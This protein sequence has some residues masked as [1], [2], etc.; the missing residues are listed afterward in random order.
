[1]SFK[2]P[3]SLHQPLEYLEI[4]DS[5]QKTSE[6][7]E[8]LELFCSPRGILQQITDTGDFYCQ[9]RTQKTFIVIRRPIGYLPSIEDYSRWKMF[10]S[11][12]K[13]QRS[14]ITNRKPRNLL[15]PIEDLVVS[16]SPQKMFWPCKALQKTEE[17][18]IPNGKYKHNFWQII[19][20]KGV[21]MKARGVL[22]QLES[23]E[24]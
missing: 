6:L 19:F 18:L 22:R 1:M 2:R 10:N 24:V 14:S 7:V 17:L 15:Q 16:Y 21:N 23:L 12:K 20:I 8:G 4:F 3:R 11:Y 9:Q 5:K 13:T